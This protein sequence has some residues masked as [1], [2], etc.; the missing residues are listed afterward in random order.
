MYSLPL[1]YCVGDR[2][3]IVE[4]YGFLQPCSVSVDIKFFLIADNFHIQ[5]IQGIEPLKS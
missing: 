3:G 2:S 1:G 4:P 5:V